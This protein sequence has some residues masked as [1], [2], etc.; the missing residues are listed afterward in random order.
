MDRPR[1]STRQRKV[2]L[3][4]VRKSP[5]HPTADEVFQSVRRELPRISLATVYRNLNLLVD[6]GLLRKIRGKGGRM[7][8]DGDRKEHVHIVCE[9]C[10]R[11][12]DI[13]GMDRYSEICRIGS[14]CT[15]YGEVSA[16]V[17]LTGICPG[18][19]NGGESGDR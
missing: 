13:H 12:A 15:G 1:R 3:E 5:N 2:I 18:C 10:G 14:E 7:R 16:D 6:Q 9:R 4:E 17:R 8:F 19:R 11:I